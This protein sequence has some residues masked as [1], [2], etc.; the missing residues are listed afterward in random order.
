[1]PYPNGETGQPLRLVHCPSP[2]SYLATYQSC[3]ALA[4]ERI[5]RASDESINH[6]VFPHLIQYMREERVSLESL[7]REEDLFN[8]DEIERALKARWARQKLMEV[9]DEILQA[10]FYRCPNEL[11]TISRFGDSFYLVLCAGSSLEAKLERAISVINM[12]DLFAGIETPEFG[13]YSKTRDPLPQDSD[14]HY[15]FNI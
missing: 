3:Y 2:S 7:L 13:A 4:R 8:M 12:T 5:S 1:M 15:F 9:A 6:Y 11:M 10:I 14:P